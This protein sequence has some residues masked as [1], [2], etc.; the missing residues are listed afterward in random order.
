MQLWGS[1][2]SL[3]P[4]LLSPPP[5][6]RIDRGSANSLSRDQP[7][8]TGAPSRT[9]NF[10]VHQQ[11]LR[12]AQPP[13]V[14]E[15]EWERKKAATA[16]SVRKREIIRPHDASLTSL[17]PIASVQ[18]A[19][20][21]HFFHLS[22]SSFFFCCHLEFSLFSGNIG[23]ISYVPRAGLAAIHVCV[24]ALACVCVWNGKRTLSI[25]SWVLM[26]LYSPG[27]GGSF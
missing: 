12:S 7:C 24:R 11:P 10:P 19:V 20:I 13:C 27:V 21:L 6:C 22:F 3:P 16:Q 17:W 26:T 25:L 4:F 14:Q 9:A 1:S 18:P 2:C 23:A 5:E 15:R 8:V